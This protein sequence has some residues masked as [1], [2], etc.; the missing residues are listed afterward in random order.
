MTENY[1]PSFS[2][3]GALPSMGISITTPPQ[4]RSSVCL[5]ITTTPSPLSRLS[6]CQFQPLFAVRRTI[7]RVL[8]RNALYGHYTKPQRVFWKFSI[9][10]MNKTLLGKISGKGLPARPGSPYLPR[11][12]ALFTRTHALLWGFVGVLLTMPTECPYLPRKPPFFR[13]A[14]AN[15]PSHCESVPTVNIERFRANIEP[16]TRDAGKEVAPY[17]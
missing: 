11:W 6:I 3:F 4:R 2:D 17:I 8:G 7:Y 9:E 14:R 10:A 5:Y 16:H 13:F 1:Q 12:Y 15:I